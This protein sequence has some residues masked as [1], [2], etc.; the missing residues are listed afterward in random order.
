MDVVET[1]P[2]D[3][4]SAPKPESGRGAPSVLVV[5]DSSLYRRMVAGLI[6]D[7]LGCRVVFANDG[8]EALSLVESVHPSVVLSD[9]RMPRMDGFELV[10]AIRTIHPE[11]PVILMTA[12]GSEAVAMR[13]LQASAASYIPKDCLAAELVNTLRQVLTIV[14]GNQR[15]RQLLACQTSRTGSF[16][17]GNDPHLF[18]DLVALIQEELLSFSIGDATT[19]MRVAIAL[20]EALANALYHG[21]LECSSELRQQDERHFFQLAEERLAS[22]PYRSRRIHLETKIDRGA[23]R[24]DIRDEGPGFDVASLD[25]PFEPEDLMR[26]G[27][28]GMVLIRS[29]FDEVIHND[30]GNQITLIKR[31]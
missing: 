5:D 31:T 26:I 29:F 11:I 20:H 25:K 23:V 4:E 16:E 13:A 17:L 7:G 3:S 8:I 6:R 19:R 12:Y 2:I 18:P 27:G 28:R 15:R 30:S 1:P 14:E 9:I 24:I 10:Q 22:E 21:N